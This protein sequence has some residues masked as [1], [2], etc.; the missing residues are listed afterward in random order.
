MGL[1]AATGN[2]YIGTQDDILFPKNWIEKHID[3]QKRPGGPW[4]VFNRI[5]NALTS[6]RTPQGEEEFWGH[7]SNPRNVPIVS[8]WQY[9][10]GHSFSIPMAIAK[11]LRH[12][13]LFNKRWGF[14]DIY[15][16]YL[17][18]KAGCRFLIDTDTIV[19]HQDHGDAFESIAARGTEA[20]ETRIRERSINRR[21]FYDLAGFCPEYGILS[22][23]F[24]YE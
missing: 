24:G 22:D 11:S 16:S 8:R 6:D 18:F 17:C 9:A 4:F 12:E 23:G 20:L 3:W 10:S 2:I 7:I 13:E 14:E 5:A 15:W 21:L 1:D 19:T